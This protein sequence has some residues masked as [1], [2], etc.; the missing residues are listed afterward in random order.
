MFNGADLLSLRCFSF[1]AASGSVDALI[2]SDLDESETGLVV[3]VF[4]FF[5]GSFILDKSMKPTTFTCG[6]GV[7]YIV[8]FVSTFS[9]F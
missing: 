2:I 5:L 7:S 9:M 6:L 3:F 4:F 1:V 8:S